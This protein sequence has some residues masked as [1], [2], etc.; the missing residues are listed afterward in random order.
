MA[1]MR[2]RLTCAA[3]ERP[4]ARSRMRL[5]CATSADFMSFVLPTTPASSLPVCQL[6]FFSAFSRRVTRSFSVCFGRS[7]AA[8]WA[9]SITVVRLRLTLPPAWMMGTRERRVVSSSNK[10]S[11]GMV[12]PSLS[13]SK[14]SSCMPSIE[15]RPM[16]MIGPSTRSS[17]ASGLVLSTSSAT[18]FFKISM[19]WSSLMSFA[20]CST[21][22]AFSSPSSLLFASASSA[23]GAAAKESSNHSWIILS[24]IPPLRKAFLHHCRAILPEVVFSIERGLS[25]WIPLRAMP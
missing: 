1:E 20:A 22:F 6:D 17:N 12:A 10:I 21:T 4:N 25:K 3:N 23:G 5:A 18:V 7:I 8:R 9:Q 13:S 15:P 14:P 16:S 24:S 11:C 19:I 2:P